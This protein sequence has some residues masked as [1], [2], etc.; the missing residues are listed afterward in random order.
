MLYVKWS[1]F[2]LRQH[3]C[4]TALPEK[5]LMGWLTPCQANG[6]YKV[7]VVYAWLLSHHNWE[8]YSSKEQG[9]LVSLQILRIATMQSNQKSAR[10]KW[11]YPKGVLLAV[12]GDNES[13]QKLPTVYETVFD[14][15]F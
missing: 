1:V 14:K 10:L 2:L 5:R 7:I 12:V 4:Y 15:N 11:K 6:K 13:I 8:S 3:Y 9:I